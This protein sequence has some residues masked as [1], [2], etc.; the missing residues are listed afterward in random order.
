[1]AFNPDIE[2]RV[3]KFVSRWENT[4]HKNMFGGV[5]HLL[6]GNMFCGVLKDGLILRLGEKAAGNALA[7]PHVRPFDV[8]GR[9]MKGWV[10]VELD[11]FKTEDE[12]GAWLGRA[13]DFVQSMPPK[14]SAR[15][16]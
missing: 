7:Q 6:N 1:M 9:P 8:T 13:R 4:S 14:S 2:A 10:M 16:G 5:C 3:Q 11:G 15:K 12:L